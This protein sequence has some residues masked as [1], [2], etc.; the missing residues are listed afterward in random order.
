[1]T[2]TVQGNLT[3]TLSPVDLALAVSGP[4]FAVSTSLEKAKSDVNRIRLS[5]S[6]TVQ[7]VGEKYLVNY[8]LRWEV[9]VSSMYL[10]GTPT[11]TYHNLGVEGAALL[12]AGQPVTILDDQGKKLTLSIKFPEKSAAP[13]PAPGH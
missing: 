4:E 12:R 7:L 1:M 13:A 3:Q 9:P 2:L 8:A 5:F 10:G 11:V 6:G